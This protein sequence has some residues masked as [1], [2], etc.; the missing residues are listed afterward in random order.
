MCDFS[1]QIETF[2]KTLQTLFHRVL[3]TCKKSG[4]IKKQQME[5]IQKSLEKM[6]LT[7]A[8]IVESCVEEL[9]STCLFEYMEVVPGSNR[10]Q[11]KGNSTHKIEH[12]MKVFLRVKL[13]LF[14]SVLSQNYS[15]LHLQKSSIQKQKSF[16]QVLE[17]IKIKKK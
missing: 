14:S 6:N 1:I 7:P 11:G 13:K 10:Y 2:E 16:T 17:D 9:K 12:H 5:H 15:F 3:E 8:L 4:M